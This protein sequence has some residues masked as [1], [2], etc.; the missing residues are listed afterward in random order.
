MARSN[1]IAK[2][3]IKLCEQKLKRSKA[4]IRFFDLSSMD[5]MVT[6]KGHHYDIKLPEFG[7]Y[8]KEYRD[9]MSKFKEGDSIIIELD[10][11]LDDYNMVRVPLD[12]SM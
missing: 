1:N 7:A 2:S 12:Q 11:K 10:P 3:L 9:M 5:G 4:T 8:A 6:L